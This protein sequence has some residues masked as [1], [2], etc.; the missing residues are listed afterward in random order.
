MDVAS[1]HVKT[2][3]RRQLVDPDERDGDHADKAE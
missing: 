3:D 1:S 2:P